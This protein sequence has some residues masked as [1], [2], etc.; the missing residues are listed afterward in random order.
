MN[1]SDSQIEEYKERAEKLVQSRLDTE[2]EVFVKT[3]ET[4][5]SPIRDDSITGEKIV[6][7]VTTIG[8]FMKHD[9]QIHYRCLNHSED[10]EIFLNRLLTG[11]A[12]T[13]TGIVRQTSDGFVLDVESSSFH[14]D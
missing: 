11:K 14:N 2:S 8:A 13:I 3:C 5:N 12:I 4:C 7:I 1:P 6:F 9:S 10:V